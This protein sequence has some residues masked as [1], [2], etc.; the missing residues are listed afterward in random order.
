M[1]KTHITNLK[2]F[3]DWLKDLD[4]IRAIDW[5]TTGLKYTEMEPLGF[6]IADGKKAC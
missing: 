6:S 5:E 2:D 3:A 4:P 1:I